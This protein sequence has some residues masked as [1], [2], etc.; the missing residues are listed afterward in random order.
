MERRRER[1]GKARI[2]GEKE[3]REGEG[4]Q[5]ERVAMARELVGKESTGIEKE[6]GEREIEGRKR[7]TEIQREK[8]KSENTKRKTRGKGT[9]RHRNETG[10]V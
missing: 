4:K 2:R 5:G 10:K 9:P 8:W 6:N 3:V 7:G 1:E